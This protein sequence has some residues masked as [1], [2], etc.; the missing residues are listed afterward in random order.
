[1]E[2]MVQKVWQVDGFVQYDFIKLLYFLGVFHKEF[3]IADLA[4]DLP[5]ELKDVVAHDDLNGR[6]QMQQ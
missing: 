3:F 4:D 6:V 5:D 2:A 1:M